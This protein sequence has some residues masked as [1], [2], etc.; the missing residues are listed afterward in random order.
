M[1]E[2]ARRRV[3]VAC[4]GRHAMSRPCR[5]CR[6]SASLARAGLDAVV[7]HSTNGAYGRAQGTKGMQFGRVARVKM[8]RKR[9]GH[10]HGEH[11]RHG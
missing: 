2:V 5:S 7:H 6:T 8:E 4:S 1:L 10:V 3:V 9:E 11:G